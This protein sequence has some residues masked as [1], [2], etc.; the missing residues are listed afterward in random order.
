[1]RLLL[2][3][4]S[5][6]IDMMLK[7]KCPILDTSLLHT[8]SVK[9]KSLLIRPDHSV[10]WLHAISHI[11]II[12]WPLTDHKNL[13]LCLPNTKYDAWKTGL[14]FACWIKRYLYPKQ[15]NFNV[16]SI[17]NELRKRSKHTILTV[18][19]YYKY[20]SKF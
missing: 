13:P 11:F 17:K 14:F 19:K 3:L 16:V 6:L 20:C 4:S 15:L 7:F 18:Q 8:C 5:F 10:Q 1:M 12:K 9:M 2:F